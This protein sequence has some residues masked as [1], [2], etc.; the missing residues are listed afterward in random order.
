MHKHFGIIVL[1][2][3]HNQ[4]DEIKKKND[5]MCVRAKKIRESR[6]K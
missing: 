2:D 3:V 4:V 6:N 1:A 5:Q